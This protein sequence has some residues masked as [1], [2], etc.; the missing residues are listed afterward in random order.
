MILTVAGLGRLAGAVYRPPEVIVPHSVPEQPGPVALHVTAVFWVPETAARNCSVPSTATT[1]VTGVTLITSGTMIVTVADADFVLS[2]TEVAVNVTCAGLGTASGAVYRP[3]CEIVP[4]AAPEQPAP[5]RLH[6]TAV[7]DVPFTDAV[8]CCW[9]PV[10]TCVAPGETLTVIVGKMVTTALLDLVES[11]F[12]VAVTVTCAGVGTA[13]G[14]VYRPVD[15]IVPQVAPEQPVPAKLQV[16]A[17]FVV[18]VTVAVN[19]RVFRTTS[20]TVV[21]ETCTTTGGRIVTVTDDDLVIS[22]FAVAVTVTCAGFGTAAGA[23]NRPLAE[24]APQVAPEQPTPLRL[25]VTAVFVVP[26]TVAVNCCVFPATTC[27]VVGETLTATGGRMVTDA[28]AVF[29]LS[30]AEVATTVT[31]AGLGTVPGAVYKPLAEIVPQPAPEQPAPC[32]LHVTAVFVVLVT[33]A[34]NCCVF[35]ATT[36]AVV[37][38]ILTITGRR[39]VTVADADLVVSATEVAVTVTCGGLGTAPGAVYR[40]LAEIAP[41][42]APE[43]P[44]PLNFHVTLV[45]DVPSTVAVNC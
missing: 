3:V 29:V 40:P 41:Q 14:A 24:M 33:V 35:P 45:S 39:T 28:D 11:A 23:V 9:V 25:H 22:A 1:V 12:E 4:H 13:A 38:E 15:E 43:Q 21:G 27:A 32:R 16:T 2:A 17:V 10:A 37:G 44:V 30:A 36:F 19:C 31:S 7:S 42:V 5:F 26:V 8:N 20:C 34:V 18:P 6:V